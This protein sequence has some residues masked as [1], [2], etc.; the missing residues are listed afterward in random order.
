[1]I[2][3]NF[4]PSI[5]KSVGGIFYSEIKKT[6]I[7]FLIILEKEFNL[8]HRDSINFKTR[9]V[10]L[11][12]QFQKN[13]LRES[14]RYSIL[15]LKNLSGGISVPIKRIFEDDGEDY[16][17]DLGADIHEDLDIHDRY[18]RSNAGVGLDWSKLE[19]QLFDFLLVN[20][21]N[22][23]AHD[24]LSDQI[25]AV[26]DLVEKF[27][28]QEIMRICS[29]AMLAKRLESDEEKKFSDEVEKYFE[30]IKKNPADAEE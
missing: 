7:I 13:F 23:D 12:E 3:L 5:E 27:D 17:P 14:P 24:V 29:A 11:S 6:R 8:Q 28:E 18:P 10:V 1:M 16:I 26:A 19:Q 22:T 4:Y 20:R 21:F 2:A 30:Y 9:F 15:A 25:D